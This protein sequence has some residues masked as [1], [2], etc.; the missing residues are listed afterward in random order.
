[1]DNAGR[2]G[3]QAI[4]NIDAAFGDLKFWSALMTTR[5]ALP[6][7]IASAKE[8]CENSLVNVVGSIAGW[9]GRGPVAR[10]SLV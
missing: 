7:L 4:A 2:L 6:H 1:M 9:N 3:L 10:F 8:T 5:F